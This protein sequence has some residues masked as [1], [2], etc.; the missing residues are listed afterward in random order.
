M[1]IKEFDEMN[2]KL[3]DRYID[4]QKN[5]NDYTMLISD[6]F[7]YF[8]P[9]YHEDEFC[10][11]VGRDKYRSMRRYDALYLAKC[12]IKLTDTWKITLA[13]FY[14]IDMKIERIRARN[15]CVMNGTFKDTLF[16]RFSIL[17]HYESNWGGNEYHD[18]RSIVMNCQFENCVFM[19]SYARHTDWIN[20]KFIN[21]TFVNSNLCDEGSEEK[22]CTFENC[23]TI[24]LKA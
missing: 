20:C 2:Q 13:N 18:M 24:Y 10:T 17:R 21:C 9:R 22:D 8:K 12:D 3:I 1:N 11:W 16:F 15:C 4:K 7:S 5:E 6:D 14:I 23:R 19:N